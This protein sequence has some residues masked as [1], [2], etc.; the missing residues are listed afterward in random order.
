MNLRNADWTV[1]AWLVGAGF[2]IVAIRSLMDGLWH[3][4]PVMLAASLVCLP[5]FR[6]YMIRKTG[7]KINGAIYAI[8]F[9]AL[10]SIGINLA[11]DQQAKRAQDV[12]RDFQDAMK[13]RVAGKRVAA[14]AEF[15]ANKLAILIEAQRMFDA[16]RPCRRPCHPRSVFHD[17]RP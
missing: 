13:K 2:A 1:L 7:V 10:A 14:E 11:G 3:G 15:R 5:P 9:V 17:R 16:W 4:A 6:C 12:E 8:A